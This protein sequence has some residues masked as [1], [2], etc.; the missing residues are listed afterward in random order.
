M[1]TPHPG[2]LLATP[3]PLTPVVGAV[4]PAHAETYALDTLSAADSAALADEIIARRSSLPP[5]LDEAVA[6]A[7]RADYWAAAS[8]LMSVSKRLTAAAR[9]CAKGAR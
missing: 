5:W 1:T 8:K 3:I 4:A 7:V 6:D 2:E 9:K